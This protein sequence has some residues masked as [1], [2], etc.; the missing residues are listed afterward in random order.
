MMLDQHVDLFETLSTSV[1]N[2]YTDPDENVR[3]VRFQT[4]Y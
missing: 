1:Y 4:V 2:D 3:I